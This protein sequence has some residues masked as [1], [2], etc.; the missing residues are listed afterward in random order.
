MNHENCNRETCPWWRA[1]IGLPPNRIGATR[2]DCAELAAVKLAD[3]WH[4]LP[5]ANYVGQSEG[6]YDASKT[7]ILCEMNR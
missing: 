5:H 7:C 3:S 4:S 2:D 6:D 1:R